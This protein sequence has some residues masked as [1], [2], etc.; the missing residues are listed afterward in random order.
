MINS[1]NYFFILLNKYPK[2][3]NDNNK[4]INYLSKINNEENIFNNFNLTNLKDKIYIN[5]DANISFNYF[6]G[7]NKSSSINNE[8]KIKDYIV[9]EIDEEMKK[10][11]IRG[12]KLEKIINK[13]KLFNNEIKFYIILKLKRSILY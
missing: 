7:K 4:I 10:E 2:I 6:H 12:V 3:F 5:S 11:K 1:L 8:I 13:K 9:K